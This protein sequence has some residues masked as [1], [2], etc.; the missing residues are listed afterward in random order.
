MDPFLDGVYE[1]VSNFIPLIKSTN[2]G[3]K[4]TKTSNNGNGSLSKL[5]PAILLFQA[6]LSYSYP[7]RFLFNDYHTYSPDELKMCENV[8]FEVRFCIVYDEDWCWM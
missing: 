6:S 4:K 7:Y 2:R 5:L 8:K 1:Y 3:T